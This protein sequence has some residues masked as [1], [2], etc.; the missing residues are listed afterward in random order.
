MLILTLFCKVLAI[1]DII[2]FAEELESLLHRVLY[3]EILRGGGLQP[4]KIG[5]W[6]KKTQG[7]TAL[8]SGGGSLTVESY[9]QTGSAPPLPLTPFL[10]AP[11]TRTQ[12]LYT[13]P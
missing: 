4:P 9:L 12:Y 13:L 7:W 1:H 11:S 5:G 10:I 8:K 6:S 2:C 3:K